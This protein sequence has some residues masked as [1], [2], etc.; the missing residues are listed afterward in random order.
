MGGLFMLRSEGAYQ[1][2]RDILEHRFGNPFVISEA[3]RSKLD[4]WPKVHNND[5]TGLWKLSDFLLQCQVAAKEIRDLKI[6]DDIREIKNISS[7]LPDWI[8]HRWNRTI[9]KSK[10]DVGRYP[11]FEEFAQFIAK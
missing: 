3:F 1:R 10:D 2:A 4:T 7:K 9:A 8:V 11:N 5:R 6:L